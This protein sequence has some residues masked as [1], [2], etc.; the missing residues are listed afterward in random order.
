MVGVIVENESLKNRRRVFEDRVHAGRVLATMLEKYAGTDAQTM[1]V[2]AGGVP[3]A[4]GLAKRLGLALDVAVVSKITLP[5]N[6]EAGYGAVAFDGTVRINRSLAKAVRLTDAQIDQGTEITT[7]RVMRRMQRLRG[8]RPWPDLTNRTVI[9][10]DDGL[11]SGFT[12]LVAID[13]LRKKSAER[14][15]VAV[16]TAPDDT[17]AK[18][19]ERVHEVYCANIREERP[20]AVADAYVK[21]YDVSEDEA[22]AVLSG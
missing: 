5:W 19:A 9:V 16:P 21:W 20:Y 2:P 12:M 17:V 8:D 6:T 11:A 1:A 3:V 22:A 7:A 13:A 15:V 4:A 10:I 14:I 18:I